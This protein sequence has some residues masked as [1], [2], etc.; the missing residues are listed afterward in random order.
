MSDNKATKDKKDEKIEAQKEAEVIA[1]I[2]EVTASPVAAVAEPVAADV[3]AKPT[4]G[5]QG[6]GGRGRGQG[7]GGRF[8]GGR[9]RGDRREEEKKEFEE[10]VVAVDRVTRVVKGGRRM[11]FR[12]LVVIGD[13]KGRVGYATGKGNEVTVAV[14]KAVSKAKKNL[15]TVQ[16][17]DGTIAHDI[18]GKASTTRV[19]LKSAK[20][21]TGII[22]GGSVRIVLEL[23]GYNNIVAKSFGSSNKVNNVM[24]TLD[25]L[26]SLLKQKSLKEEVA[27]S[28]A[29]K[30]VMEK[31]KPSDKKPSKPAKK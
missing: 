2:K 1:D 16:V 11:R 28:E 27:A 6:Q 12:A 7:G 30:E 22:A 21:G 25:G 18:I 5:Q 4:F 3:A 8:G 13:K 20:K 14:N 17:L 31:E 9:G 10:K 19:L 23:A 15:I 29:K 24:A 26:A